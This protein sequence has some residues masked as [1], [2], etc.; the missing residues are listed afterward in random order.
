MRIV[1]PF[2][3]SLVDIK[4]MQKLSGK[5][6]SIIIDRSLI[7][8]K[9]IYRYQQLKDKRVTSS[10]IYL[11]FVFKKKKENVCLLGKLLSSSSSD[12]QVIIA[13]KLLLSR[14]YAE[15]MKMQKPMLVQY[16][17][18]P[19]DPIK[20]L[21]LLL[22]IDLNSDLSLIENLESTLSNFYEDYRNILRL[23]AEDYVT[24]LK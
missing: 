12:L 16:P 3:K 14:K 21:I 6:P 18:E 10:H 13:N 11:L 7:P 5:K 4:K 8:I 17:I 1:N 24:K 20:K 2:L 19:R 15:F 23:I 9:D 22:K